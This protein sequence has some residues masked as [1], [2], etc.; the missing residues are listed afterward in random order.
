LRN[1]CL[2]QKQGPLPL[3]LLQL[4]LLQLL[5]AA[6]ARAFARSLW[7][8]EA[9]AFARGCLHT[10]GSKGSQGGKSRLICFVAFLLSWFQIKKHC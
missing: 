8:R 1:F 6:K 4:L 10:A 5:L 7:L 9:R 3:L 2:Q